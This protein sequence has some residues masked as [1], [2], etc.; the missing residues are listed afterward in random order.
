MHL[1]TLIKIILRASSISLGATVLI[2]LSIDYVQFLTFWILG[3]EMFGL[4]RSLDFL[5]SSVN[6]NSLKS[7]PTFVGKLTYKEAVCLEIENKE[8]ICGKLICEGKL[9]Q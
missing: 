8:I 5:C 2:E 9:P 6:R 3:C 7:S 1:V 4:T